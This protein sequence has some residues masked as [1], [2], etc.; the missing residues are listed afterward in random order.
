MVDRFHYTG[1]ISCNIFNA[2]LH[3]DLDGYCSVSAEVINSL[4]NKGENQIAYLDGKNVQP[5]IKVIFGY[6]NAADVVRDN[7]GKSDLED[8]DVMKHISN[9]FNSVCPSYTNNGNNM[10]NGF[11]D[12][13]V[14]VQPRQSKSTVMT[15]H[16][17]FDGHNGAG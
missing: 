1:R 11:P 4:T 3:K 13:S 2:N 7:I 8:E 9:H 12:G 10:S 6:V 14:H 16:C 15:A 5:F 17:A